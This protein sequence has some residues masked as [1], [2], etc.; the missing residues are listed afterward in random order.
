MIVAVN[1]G[2]LVVIEDGDIGLEGLDDI[3]EEAVVLLDV[4]LQ[5]EVYDL[6]TG[7]VLP[8]GLALQLHDGEDGID[9]FVLELTCCLYALHLLVQLH[10]PHQYY[11]DDKRDYT[12]RPD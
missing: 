2:G 7:A 3:V 11:I 10:P 4:L 1:E 5:L 8:L 9:Q 6:E 12:A